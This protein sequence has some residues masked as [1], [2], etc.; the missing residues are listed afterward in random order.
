M[1][2]RSYNGRVVG[3]ENQLDIEGRQRHAVDI[4]T[5]WDG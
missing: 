4:Q 1:A 2:G 3:E 5:E